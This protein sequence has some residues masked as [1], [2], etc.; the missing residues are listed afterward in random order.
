MVVY[1]HNFLIVI[2]IAALPKRLSDVELVAYPNVQ[3]RIHGVIVQEVQH[4]LFHNIKISHGFIQ[5]VSRIKD[6]PGDHIG[7]MRDPVRFSEILSITEQ[8]D[9]LSHQFFVGHI[10]SPDTICVLV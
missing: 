6:F 3:Y 5:C 4:T 7:E 1:T 2:I 9:P 10:A 8:L